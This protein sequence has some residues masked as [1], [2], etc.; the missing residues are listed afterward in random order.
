VTRAYLP[1]LLFAG[2]A[3][4]AYAPAPSAAGDRTVAP[5]DTEW[6]WPENPENLQVLPDDIGADGLRNVMRAF[7]RGLGVRCSYCHVGE[8]DFLNWDFASDEKGH[9]E[10]AREMMRMTRQINED[11]LADIEGL[12]EHEGEGSGAFRVTCWTCHRGDTTPATMAPPEEDEAAPPEP[13][14]QP[15]PAPDDHEHAPGQE[16]QH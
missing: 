14:P 2:L 6:V 3:A 13:E 12:H 15:E 11:L 9:K 8:G 16:H 7:T 4:A 10:V 1:V 5:A